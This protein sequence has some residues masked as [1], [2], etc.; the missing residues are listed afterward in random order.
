M[1]IF[2][3]NQLNHVAKLSRIKQFNLHYV[4][5]FFSIDLG[6][7]KLWTKRMWE[8]QLK[9]SVYQI[10]WGMPARLSLRES[11]GLWL[12]CNSMIST[13]YQFLLHFDTAYRSWLVVTGDSARIQDETTENSAWFFNVLGI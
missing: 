10:L 1:S 8:M 9:S 2:L 11:E 7:F 4:A 13:R 6:T 5:F 12:K 3:Y